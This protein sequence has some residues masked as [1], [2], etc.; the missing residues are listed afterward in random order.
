MSNIDK[1]VTKFITE[2]LDVIIW[3][4]FSYVMFFNMPCELQIK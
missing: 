4:S 1:Y 3:L 2:M